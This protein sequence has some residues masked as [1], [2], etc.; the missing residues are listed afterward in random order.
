MLLPF[1]L[2]MLNVL[3]LILSSTLIVP[4]SAS[5]SLVFWPSPPFFIV[6]TARQIWFGKPADLY[7]F[8]A[9]KKV[10]SLLV[11]YV[12]VCALRVSKSIQNVAQFDADRGTN[13]LLVKGENTN[14]SNSVASSRYDEPSVQVKQFICT[15]N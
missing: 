8:Q 1:N 14:P 4:E 5:Y 10:G 7:V 11:T 13:G 3:Q 6:E 2:N 9:T 15:A 12:L